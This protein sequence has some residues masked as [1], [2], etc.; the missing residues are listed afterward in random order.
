M[1]CIYHLKATF[2]TPNAY[3]F[4]TILI[5]DTILTLLWLISSLLV[6]AE[7]AVISYFHQSKQLDITANY[8]DPSWN[9]SIDSSTWYSALALSISELYVF[10]FWDWQHCTNLCK[11][12]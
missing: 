3:H 2:R 6:V 12:P 8:G 5:H 4:K 11:E 1:L 9:W 7:V 10:D